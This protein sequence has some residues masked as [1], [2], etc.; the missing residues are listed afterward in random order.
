MSKSR[1]KTIVKQADPKVNLVVKN[2]VEVE[3]I[4]KDI[5]YIAWCDFT[6]VEKGEDGN[7]Y[8]VQKYKG[9]IITPSKSPMV[10]IEQAVSQKYLI[11]KEDQDKWDAK[12][13]VKQGYR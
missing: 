2:E 11:K 5:Q 12:T 1:R 4:K 13:L 3:P 8:S 10:W 9:D 7:L 6:I